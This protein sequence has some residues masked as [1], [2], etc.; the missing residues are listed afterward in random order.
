MV[1][2]ALRM[3]TPPWVVHSAILFHDGAVTLNGS[4]AAWQPM[5]VLA[6]ATAIRVIFIIWKCRLVFVFATKVIKTLNKNAT[7]L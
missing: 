5:A 4:V 1:D 3:L 2:G 6:A 7:F